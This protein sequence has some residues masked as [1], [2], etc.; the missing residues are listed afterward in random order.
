MSENK[1]ELVIVVNGAIKENNFPKFKSAAL[2]QLEQINTKLKTDEDFATAG[3]DVKRIKGFEQSL[4][5]NLDAIVEQLGEVNEL[6]VGVKGLKKVFSEK[7]LKLDKLVKE[8][9]ANRKEEIFKEAIEMVERND[10]APFM[11][12][13]RN[14]Y[15]S[16]RKLDAMKQAATAE[17]KIINKELTNSRELLVKFVEKHGKSIA[18]DY[19]DL[20]LRSAKELNIELPHRAERIK[21]EKELAEAKAIADEAKAKA[22]AKVETPAPAPAP[23][24]QPPKPFVKV[25]PESQGDYDKQEEWENFIS[26]LANS[27]RPVKSAREAL[28]NPENQTKAHAFSLALNEA[29]QKLNK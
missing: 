24:A 2:E 23:A 25:R 1:S 29:W 9:V 28:K 3:N 26:I 6:M 4:D 22:E 20:E 10:K 8:E 19:D 27:F 18:P 13:I 14:S 16:K 17:A 11:D 12:R 7:R 5:T 15:K 21:A